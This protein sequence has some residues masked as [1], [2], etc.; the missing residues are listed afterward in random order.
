MEIEF[1]GKTT[2]G[3][4]VYGD[5]WGCPLTEKVYIRNFENDYCNDYEVLPET[6]GQYTGIKDKDG[7]KIFEWDYIE[8]F[9][10]Y[11]DG[12][13]RSQGITVMRRFDNLKN[14]DGNNIM[15][16]CPY[17]EE[18]YTKPYNYKNFKLVGNKFDNPELIK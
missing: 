14:M 13:E 1:R 7:N 11:G 17:R 2:E 5:K 15:P 9:H 3:K 12:I 6:V 10:I 4:W 8:S 18:S 16:C